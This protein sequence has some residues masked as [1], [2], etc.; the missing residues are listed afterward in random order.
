MAGPEELQLESEDG[1]K[2]AGYRWRATSQRATL[3]LVHGYCDH[4]H[5]YPELVEAALRRQLS[6]AAVDL[7]GHGK[8]G[9]AQGHIESFTRYLEDIEALVRDVE[10]DSGT[11]FLVGHSMGGLASIRYVESGRHGQFA[12]LVLSSPYLGLALAVPAW[13]SAAGRFM[14]RVWPGFSMP[15]GIPLTD[16]S[17]NPDV[18]KRTTEDKLYGRSATARAFTEQLA[19]H[20][21]AV[22]Q[23]STVQLPTL[24]LVGGS[25]RIAQPQ[26]AQRFYEALEVEDKELVVFD[27][28]FHEIFADPERERVF[29][30]LFSWIDKRVPAPV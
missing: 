14:S 8:S 3:I 26:A 21:D 5:R 1:T 22:E 25:D 19:A 9:G 4:A 16:L 23:V 28:M 30:K 20:R 10:P 13:K 29:D 11:M 12:G 6:V 24:L 18:V 27:P 2:L 15:T 17:R 7:R